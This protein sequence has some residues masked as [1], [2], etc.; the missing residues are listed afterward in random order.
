MHEVNQALSNQVHRHKT[1]LE[2]ILTTNKI[3]LSPEVLS[4]LKPIVTL[5]YRLMDGLQLGI[6]FLDKCNRHKRFLCKDFR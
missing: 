5:T 6:M 4:S 3:I 1:N 2:T